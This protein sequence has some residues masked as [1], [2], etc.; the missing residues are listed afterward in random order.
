M[1]TRAPSLPHG[2]AQWPAPRCR[3]TRSPPS[4]STPP[5]PRPAATPFTSPPPA[6]SCSGAPGGSTLF[7]LHGWLG[8]PF[9]CSAKPSWA[10]LL[11]WLAKEGTESSAGLL[12][13][14]LQ[15]VPQ[16]GG[17]DHHKGAAAG[18]T[19]HPHPRPRLPAR[20]SGALSPL[21]PRASCQRRR[22][23]PYACAPALAWNHRTANVYPGC[24]L[25]GGHVHGMMLDF[26]FLASIMPWSMT[27][28]PA[29]STFARPRHLHCTSAGPL[30]FPPPLPATLRCAPPARAATSGCGTCPRCASCCGSL[31]PAWTAAPSSLPRYW[32]L[33][34]CM[35]CCGAG[36]C[37]GSVGSWN[38]TRRAICCLQPHDHLQPSDSSLKCQRCQWPHCF[39]PLL[40][41][42]G[43]LFHHLGVQ[44][45]QDPCFRAAERQAPVSVMESWVKGA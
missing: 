14:T 15:G 34:G 33:A 3:S 5:A 9:F 12:L 36:V 4:C 6:P 17:A 24:L 30:L 29:P 42:T 8:K 10:E 23:C 13:W 27:A 20:V 18:R 22:C 28:E 16:P 25:H 38:S 19:P 45:R 40:C 43:W 32:A 35:C 37:G 26:F 41:L 31:C 44:R 2:R 11:A 1:S 21:L 7:S 39:M